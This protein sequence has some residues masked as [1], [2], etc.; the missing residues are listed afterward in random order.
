MTNLVV[1]GLNT[2]EPTSGFDNVSTEENDD[3]LWSRK[4]NSDTSD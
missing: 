4:R 2:F 1:S 3:A